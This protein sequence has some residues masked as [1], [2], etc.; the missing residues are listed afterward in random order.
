MP[1]PEVAIDRVA[2]RD[3]AAGQP[4]LLSAVPP[5]PVPGP[6]AGRAGQRIP[7]GTIGLALDAGLAFG[8]GRHGS[9]AGC[10]L[11]LDALRRRPVRRALDLGCGSGILAIA[12]AKLWRAQVAGLGYRPA[13]GGGGARQRHRQRR[14]QRRSRRHRR[15]GPG[16]A[17]PQAGAVRPR[18]RQHP[19]PAADRHGGRRRRGCLRPAAGWCSPGS[20]SRQGRAVLAAYRSPRS[21]PRPPDRRGRL[22]DPDPRSL[23]GLNRTPSG[24]VPGR[25]GALS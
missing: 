14:R 23:T 17:D 15:R 8:S 13:G 19:R 21:A 12:I 5:R 1:A 11:A 18:R 9:T 6:S 25:E 24:G 2:E 4:R 16:A 3:W 7:A 10:L 20:S 22:A